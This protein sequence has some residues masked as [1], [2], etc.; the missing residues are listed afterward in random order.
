MIGH[1]EGPRDV[2]HFFFAAAE[3]LVD[4]H[5]GVISRRSGADGELIGFEDDLLGVDYPVV[6]LL[7]DRRRHPEETAFEVRAMIEGEREEGK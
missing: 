5:A 4:E 6:N 7:G 1:G 3:L 2:L